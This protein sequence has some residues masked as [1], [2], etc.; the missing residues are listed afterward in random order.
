[1]FVHSVIAKQTWAGWKTGQCEVH[2]SAKKV[3]RL[4][5]KRVLPVF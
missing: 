4:L 2:E 3:F 5:M 1:M